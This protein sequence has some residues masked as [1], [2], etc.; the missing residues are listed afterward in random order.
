MKILFV[1]GY[2]VIN[3]WPNLKK[4]K[5]YSYESARQQLIETLH[6]YANYEDCNINIVFDA[7]KVEGNLENKEEVDKRLS[8]VFTKDGETADNYIERQ[9]NE[10][11]RRFEVL[12]V[13]SDWLEQQTIFQRGAIR[14]SS[15]EFYHI[16]VNMEKEIIS[17]TKKVTK[18]SKNLLEDSIDKEVL[19]KLEKMRRS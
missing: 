5:E 2:N 16:I 9:V 1:D 10:L 19:K 4:I 8:V 14:V 11:G 6:N 15:L 18:G 7:H 17:E 13:T 12:V 3:S